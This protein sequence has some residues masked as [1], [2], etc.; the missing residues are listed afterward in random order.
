MPT[1]SRCTTFGALAVALGLVFLSVVVPVAHAAPALVR[2]SGYLTMADG[3][4]LSYTVV[5]PDGA[6]PLPTLFEYS[7]YAPGIDPDAGYIRQFVEGDGGYAYIGVNL[8]GTGC[9]DGTFDFFQP[10][11]A[12]DGAAVIAWITQQP[13]SNGKVGMI[14]KSY[15]GITQLFVAEE[16]PPG[17]VAIAPGH[18]FGDAYRDIARPGGIINKGF[19]TLWSFIGRPSYE[20]TGAPQEVA[21]GNLK[22]AN[23][24]TAE[25]RGIPTNPFVQLLQH[26]YDDA[27]VQ[28]RSPD[29]HLDRIN[30]PVLATLAWQDE[31]L[32]SRQTHVLAD[33]QTQWWATLTNGDHGMARTPT[34]LADLER[35]YDHFLKGEDN[36]W[37][38]RPRVQVWWESGRD[39]G[40]RA[41]GWTTALPEW[42]EAARIASGTLTPT[43][44]H[45]RAGGR[46]DPA[47][48]PTDE[49]ADTYLYAPGIGSQGIGNPKY[50]YP[51][52]PDHYM[53]DVGP[54]P[55]TFAAYTT[56]PFTED[57]TF[58]GSASLDLWLASQATDTDVQVTLTEVR[59]DGQ[60]LYI[61]KGW[62][63]ASQRALDPARSSALRPFE[64]HQESDSA[65]LVPG[66]PA[67]LRVEIFPFGH[68]V[69]AGSRL[70]VWIEAPTIV[71]ELWSFVP[72]PQPAQNTVLHDAAH[73]SALVLP[74]VPNDAAR[75]ATL[76]ECGT[77]IRQPCRPDA[78]GAGGASVAA[79]SEPAAP[80]D[81]TAL[82]P[83]A[84]GEGGTTLPATGGS[85][86][87]A[88]AAVLLVLGLALRRAR[89]M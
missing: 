21:T 8:R 19:S 18:F 43:P 80:A 13:W 53:W 66:E 61:Q 60:E 27:L 45:L 62:L 48:P 89:A 78:L 23:G 58:L 9:S 71:P 10:Q 6:G 68:V 67:L 52:L 35:F 72:Y 69:R 12:K 88:P 46:L 28:E 3:V 16:Q 81:E 34:E 32:A 51:D 87:L 20:F 1:R 55:G 33:L 14:G 77:L 75:I 83:A 15:P 56:D 37:E 49:A 84:T 2:E 41:P 85:V 40:A 65:S 22:C 31:Q 79:P 30:V 26:P 82:T 70:R 74:L 17:L 24:E 54:A 59:P 42:D 76:P 73:P 63:K 39:G 25:L 44:L 50:G 36:G 4:Q 7:G 86:F 57:R 64:T 38:A 5:R 11:E 47:S 29:K